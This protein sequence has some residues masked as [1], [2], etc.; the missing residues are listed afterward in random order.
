VTW[1]DLNAQYWGTFVEKDGH[2]A[3]KRRGAQGEALPPP[4]RVRVEFPDPW[5]Q[6]PAG[7]WYWRDEHTVAVRP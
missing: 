3:A 5:R 7:Q 2:F 4:R 6:P 1:V